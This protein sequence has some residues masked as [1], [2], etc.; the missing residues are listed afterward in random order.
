MRS[1]YLFAAPW[2]RGRSARLEE[3]RRAMCGLLHMVLC[4]S[5]VWCP[6]VVH[7]AKTPPGHRRARCCLWKRGHPASTESRRP[8]AD[9][10]RS[11]CPAV[12][13]GFFVANIW[14]GI[15]TLYTDTGLA[16]LRVKN[17]AEGPA[18]LPPT[19]PSTRAV[20]RSRAVSFLASAVQHGFELPG[21]QLALWTIKFSSRLPC[22]GTVPT[23]VSEKR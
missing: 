18:L 5:F 11:S 17:L 15:W 9:R 1:D 14:S 6:C 21:V 10:S 12:P 20:H 16:I 8:A 2:C 4:Q 3:A 13:R 23:C 7:I 19:T 22:I